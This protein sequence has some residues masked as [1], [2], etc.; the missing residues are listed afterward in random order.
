MYCFFSFIKV[1]FALSCRHIIHTSLQKLLNHIFCYGMG[2]SLVSE[3]NWIVY[4]QSV[5]SAPEMGYSGYFLLIMFQNNSFLYI[6][7][8]RGQLSGIPGSTGKCCQTMKCRHLTLKLER[9]KN[10]SI[11]LSYVHFLNISYDRLDILIFHSKE[12]AL[13]ISTRL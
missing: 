4:A 8:S 5:N 1:T 13:T 9:E 11:C 10:I 7:G 2:N 12:I 6:Y 3:L